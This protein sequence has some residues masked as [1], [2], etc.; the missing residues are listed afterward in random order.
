MDS[1]PINVVIVFIPS[2]LNKVKIPS[3]H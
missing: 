2:V 3:N 1:W